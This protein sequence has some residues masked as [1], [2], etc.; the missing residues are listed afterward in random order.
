MN[1]L[2]QRGSPQVQLRHLGSEAP[3][4]HVR[5]VGEVVLVHVLH[6]GRLGSSS[7]RKKKGESTRKITGKSLEKA[8]ES[9]ETARDSLENHWLRRIEK[10]VELIN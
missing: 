3:T 4:R 5:F 1:Q 7:P 2:Q 6:L 10:G 8:G 9:L